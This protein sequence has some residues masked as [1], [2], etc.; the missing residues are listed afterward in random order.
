MYRSILVATDGSP[1]ATQALDQAIQI[2]SKFDAELHAVYVIDTRRAS[3][4]ATK[5]SLH[6][7]GEQAIRSAKKRAAQC[8]VSLTTMITEG[9]PAEEILAY[10]EDYS[11]DLIILGAKGKSGLE[12][13]FFGTVAERVARH[14]DTSV[15]VAR[16]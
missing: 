3:T 10:A 12:R 2:A 6:D 14:A 9:I 1:D 8:D 16:R 4:A 13:F 7:L 5:D 15:L 11:I